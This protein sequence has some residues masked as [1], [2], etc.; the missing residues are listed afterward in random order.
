MIKDTL[1]LEHFN[2]SCTTTSVDHLPQQK[3][4]GICHFSTSLQSQWEQ[5]SFAEWLTREVWVPL[6]VTGGP[7]LEN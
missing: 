4:N 7:L 6:Q 2:Q 1:W 3:I 5:M